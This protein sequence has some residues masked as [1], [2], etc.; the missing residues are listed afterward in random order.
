MLP[1]S[2]YMRV[3]AVVVICVSCVVSVLTGVNVM[4]CM[5]E[6]RR[7]LC[8]GVADLLLWLGQLMM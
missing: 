5:G 6:L 2:T 1:S 7:F 4:V 8:Y 3:M